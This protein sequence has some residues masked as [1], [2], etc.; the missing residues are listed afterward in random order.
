MHG[1]NATVPLAYNASAADVAQAI[2]DFSDWIGVIL[3]ERRELS[4]WIDNQGDMFEWRLTF[5]PYE[6]DVAELRVRRTMPV[7]PSGQLN[8]FGGGGR[9]VALELGMQSRPSIWGSLVLCSYARNSLLYNMLSVY[10]L[11][12]GIRR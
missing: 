8:V 4:E 9:A 6:G 7:A 5:S 1:A 2:N 11:V 12:A 3:A 10:L